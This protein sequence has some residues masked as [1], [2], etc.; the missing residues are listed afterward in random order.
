MRHSADVVDHSVPSCARSNPSRNSRVS[1]GSAVGSSGFGA[2]GVVPLPADGTLASGAPEALAG[3]DATPGLGDRLLGKGRAGTT[4][5]GGGTGVGGNRR[6]RSAAV[7]ADGEGFGSG[8]RSSGTHPNAATDSANV[9][10]RI[11]G[12][13]L[14]K[15]GT[16]CAEG[17]GSWFRLELAT[18]Q[19]SGCIRSS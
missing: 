15:L 16:S 4:A 18:N 6:I 5:L 2:A 11:T 14:A 10:R 7:A 19:V 9:Q 13:M 1:T 8:G 12:A 3:A 17:H